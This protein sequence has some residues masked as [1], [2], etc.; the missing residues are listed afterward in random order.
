[1]TGQVPPFIP[2]SADDLH[3][4]GAV[5]RM[6]FLHY[7]GRRMTWSETDRLLKSVPGKGTW[8]VA[9]DIA[10]SR[11]GITVRNVEPVYYERLA[12]EGTAYLD[13]VFG[14]ETA[15]Y[16]RNRSNIETVLP[17]IPE[18]LSAVSHETRRTGIAE[19]SDEVNGGALAGVTVNSSVLNGTGGFSLH[20]VLVYAADANTLTLHDPG[21]PPVPSR[22]VTTEAFDKSFNYPGGNGGVD[23]FSR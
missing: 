5:F 16:Y 7:L 6:L 10:L 9:G 1:M 13:R 19:I 2:N 4:V 8:T 17:D 21:L 12:R 3:C 23:F 11:A 22:T 18:F 20:Y 15:A 14:A